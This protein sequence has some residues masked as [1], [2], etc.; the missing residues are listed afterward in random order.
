MTADLKE[1][2]RSVWQPLVDMRFSPADPARLEIMDSDLFV[3]RE[4]LTR[5]LRL[6]NNSAWACVLPSE[7]LVN[8][9]LFLRDIWP[10]IRATHGPE[11][12]KT[13]RSGWMTVSHVCS[14]WRSAAVGAPVLWAEY[15]NLVDTPAQYLPT[16]FARSRSYPLNLGATDL[17][18]SDLQVLLGWLSQSICPRV[19]H[20]RLEGHEASLF[21]QLLPHV[22]PHL[23]NLRTLS[24]EITSPTDAISLP[25][26]LFELSHIIHL[27]LAGLRLPWDSAIFSTN[28]TELELRFDSGDHQSPPRDSDFRDM[29]SNMRSLRT[30][31]LADL[32]PMSQAKQLPLPETLR[33]FNF[34]NY[35][36]IN[37]GVALDFLQR[38]QIP[39]ACT[40]TALFCHKD[41]EFVM[42]VSSEEIGRFLAS[43]TI[44]GAI[45]RCGPTELLLLPY[46][47]LALRDAQPSRPVP[48]QWRTLEPDISCHTFPQELGPHAYLHFVNA[49]DLSGAI[50]FLQLDNLQTITVYPDVYTTRLFNQIAPRTL[51]VQHAEMWLSECLPLFHAL[52][53]HTDVDFV[54]FPRL[55]VLVL[56]HTEL[57]DAAD[58][59]MLVAELTALTVVIECR[60]TRDAPLREVVVSR[61]LE[62]W[63]IW[64]A[65]RGVVQVTLL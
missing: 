43:F 32:I 62:S 7:I 11:D 3:L 16:L 45:E 61:V 9:F 35:S 47:V 15:S 55:E 13:F 52:L 21:S 58:E 22:A 12:P 56:Y 57:A 53:D 23:S 19:Q 54:L 46:E 2:A 44:F 27:T 6:R 33:N 41:E 59:A 28:L 60:K 50:P 14:K 20:L 37:A 40:R 1:D 24:L 51:R 48:Q 65:L 17:E 39:K 34:F 31:S 42:Q 26:P 64:D 49:D 29:C 63:G 10:P 8:I 36:A 4:T 30:L 38:L 5:A 25:Q 18:A